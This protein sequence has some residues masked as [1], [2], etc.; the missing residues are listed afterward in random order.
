M[1]LSQL[2]FYVP[3]E[4]VKQIIVE[5]KATEVRLLDMTWEMFIKR[6]KEEIAL[7]NKLS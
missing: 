2:E 1:K 6:H 5:S 3:N 7:R 4:E